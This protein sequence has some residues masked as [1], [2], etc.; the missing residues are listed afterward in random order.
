MYF[1]HLKKLFWNQPDDVHP[2]MSPTKGELKNRARTAERNQGAIETWG[3]N[4]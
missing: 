2:F 1:I 3:K 4:A